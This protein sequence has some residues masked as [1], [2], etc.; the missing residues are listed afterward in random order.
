[1]AAQ[2]D[3]AADRTVLPGHLVETLGLAEDGRLLFQGFVGE[4]VQLPV[5]LVEVQVH[6]LPPLLVRAVLGEKESHV[7][8]GRD[9]LNALRLLLDGPQ[10]I[11]EIEQPP[12]NP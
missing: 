8:L 2:V 11:L 6:D 1:L 7:L 5:Y 10:L 9:V 3:T 4:I 12:G